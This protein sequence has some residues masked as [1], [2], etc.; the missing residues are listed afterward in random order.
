MW[1]TARELALFAIRSHVAVTWHDDSK[2]DVWTR[3]WARLFVGRHCPSLVAVALRRKR[4]R[5]ARF[6]RWLQPLLH[7]SRCQMLLDRLFFLA[8]RQVS[9]PVAAIVRGAALESDILTFYDE[10]GQGVPASRSRRRPSRARR[11]RTRR[12]SRR[13]RRRRGADLLSE[14]VIYSV[15]AVTIAWQY[16]SDQRKRTKG[17]RREGQGGSA[18]RGG[19]EE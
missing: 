17:G 5:G 16:D 10:M 2:C 1:T 12:R 13:S 18:D 11:R 19:A 7:A 6:L 14:F 8:V 4:L 9:K 3:L 15:A